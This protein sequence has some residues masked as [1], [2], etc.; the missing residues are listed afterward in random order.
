VLYPAGAVIA[1]HDEPHGVE[2]GPLL[3]VHGVGDHDLAIP[4]VF[5]VESFDEVQR[6]RED[7][8]VETVEGDLTAPGMNTGLVENSL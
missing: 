4:G 8:L 2:P 6:P 5:R 1:R 7:R 3:P